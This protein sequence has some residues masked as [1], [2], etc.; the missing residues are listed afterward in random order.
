MI[1]FNKHVAEDTGSGTISNSLKILSYNVWF[2]EDMEMHKRMKALGDLI[3][4]HSPELICFQV[5]SLSRFAL[6][7]NKSQLQYG[8]FYLQE[9]TPNIYDVFRQSSWWKVY[10]CSVSNEI[11]NSRPYFCMLV[12]FGSPP[13]IKFILYVDLSQY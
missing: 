9:V 13:R 8:H 1:D 7:M 11:V 3:Q 2:R 12:R 6:Y 10:R 4:Q 5:L